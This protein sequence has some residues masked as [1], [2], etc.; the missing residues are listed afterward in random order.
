[1][2]LKCES[3]FFVV[4]VEVA[5]PGRA[6]DKVILGIS[7]CSS[8]IE[9]SLKYHNERKFSRFLESQSLEEALKNLPWPAFQ[10]S[11]TLYFL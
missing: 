2:M 7:F 8:G 10:N 11:N 9:G 5:K 6:S 4:G 3:M 1:M